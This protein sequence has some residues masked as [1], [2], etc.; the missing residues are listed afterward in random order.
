MRRH[1]GLSLNGS[2]FLQLVPCVFFEAPDCADPHCLMKLTQCDHWTRTIMKGVVANPK[3][4]YLQYFCYDRYRLRNSTERS[5]FSS[6]TCVLST[7]STEQRREVCMRM[8]GRFTQCSRI[9]PKA[10]Q[11]TLK[12][13][14]LLLIFNN[15][16]GEITIDLLELLSR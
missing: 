15:L 10:Q 8:P 3:L 4:K 6:T 16:L 12:L 13:L 2:T 9:S 5:K 14:I 7:R 11:K 1:G